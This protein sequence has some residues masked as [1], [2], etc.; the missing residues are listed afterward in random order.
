[1]S[2]TVAAT[3]VR[4]GR[5]RGIIP[6]RAGP[7]VAVTITA[8]A[9]PVELTPASRFDDS[10]QATYVE[11]WQVLRTMV[12]KP[13]SMTCWHGRD[14]HVMVTATVRAAPGTTTDDIKRIVAEGFPKEG[15]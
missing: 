8:P 11:V 10:L 4:S 6:G 5:L 7:T 9:M 3:E 15:Q 1:M 14:G 13:K 12:G 2:V